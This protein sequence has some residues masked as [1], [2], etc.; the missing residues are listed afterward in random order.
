MGARRSLKA[1]AVGGLVVGAL[2][3]T[4][5]MTDGLVSAAA[6][7]IGLFAVPVSIGIA[8]AY[9][10][11]AWELRR[12]VPGLSVK[13]RLRS[14]GVRTCLTCLEPMRL[15]GEVWTCHRCSD[16]RAIA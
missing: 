6:F 15:D 4:A 12:S 5:R 7:I 3:T 11:H 16:D 10:W 9:A 13:R 1:L 8:V 2:L 14:R